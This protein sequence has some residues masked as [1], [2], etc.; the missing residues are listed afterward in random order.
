[1]SYPSIVEA[2][3]AYSELLHRAA[4]ADVAYYEHDSAIMSDADYDDIKLAIEAIEIEFPTLVSADSPTQKVSGKATAAFANVKHSQRMESLANT[5]TPAAVAEWAAPLGGPSA[6]FLGE[7]K[8]DGLSCRLTYQNGSLIRAVT[9]GDGDVGEDVTHTARN[10]G[11]VPLDITAE[12]TPEDDLVEVNGEIYLPKSKFEEYNARELAKGKKGKPF[13]NCRNGAAGALRRADAESMKDIGI[14]FMAFGTTDDTFPDIDSDATV[15]EHLGEIFEV[16]PHVVI[17]GH[18]DAIRTQIGKW[19]LDRPDL[20]FDI[21]GVVWK[22]DS[23]AERAKRGSTSKAPRWATAYKFPAE[24]KVTEL[25]DIVVQTGR[26]GA[27]TPVGVLEPVFVGGVTVS[28]VT[29]HNEDE[30][31]RLGLFP[32]ARVIVQRAGD[33]IPQ[34]VCLADDSARIKGFY[35]LPTECPSCGSPAVREEGQAVRRCVNTA[36]CPAQRQAHLEHFVSRKAM[37]IDGLGPSQI[38][39]LLRYLKFQTASQIMALPETQVMDTPLREEGIEEDLYLS[40]LMVNW[41]GY[42]KSS[43]AKLM[44]AIKKARSPDLARFIFALGIRNVG[45]T[46]AKDI[47]KHLKTVDAFFTAVT[48][49]DGFITAGVEDINGVGP[50][51]MDSIERHFR[52]K[53]NYDEVF[54]LRRV[55]DIRDMPAANASEVSIFSGEVICFTGGLDRWSRDQALLIAEELGAKV[56]NSAAK[57]TT[58][59]VCGSG[60]GAV[61]IKKAEDNG[62]RCEDEAWF[63]AEVERAIGLGY[64]LDVMD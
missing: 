9:R 4:A 17:T 24:Q 48:T 11:G 62:T 26:T 45:E 10:A 35:T 46:T 19:S 53:A 7:L 2:E 52:K 40:D 15:L 55:M 38:A 27:L 63:I 47:A 59:L 56:T 12:I 14:R 49:D 42:G 25:K 28:N 58:I 16:V 51:V 32:G 37:D 34:V 22:L 60:V 54:A 64:K 13:V 6:V 36:T 8:M 57:S 20:D 31:N 39:D 1:M 30:I 44:A 43:V 3:I 50:I 5:F 23:R 61:K 41:D 29:L 18:A 21:D 33:V